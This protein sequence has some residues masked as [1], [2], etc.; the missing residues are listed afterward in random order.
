MKVKNREEREKVVMGRENK[1]KGLEF[2][3]LGACPDPMSMP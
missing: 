3:P 1:R 2:A